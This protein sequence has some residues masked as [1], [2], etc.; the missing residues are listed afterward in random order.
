MWHINTVLHIRDHIKFIQDCSVG[1]VGQTAGLLCYSGKEMR[2]VLD[3]F[4]WL[5]KAETGTRG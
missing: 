1:T 3:L 2:E 4:V 5:G